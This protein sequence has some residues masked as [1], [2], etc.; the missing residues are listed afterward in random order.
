[1]N[2][3]IFILN[4]YSLFDLKV[5]QDVVAYERKAVIFIMEKIMGA[6]EDEDEEGWGKDST[7]I[8]ESKLRK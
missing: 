6:Y 2:E 3:N 5:S 1:M 7:L 4:K 8:R